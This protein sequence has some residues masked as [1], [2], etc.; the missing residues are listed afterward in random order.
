M[1]PVDTSPPST[2]ASFRGPASARRR[3]PE[4]LEV[5][6]ILG[7]VLLLNYLP[8]GIL[9]IASLRWGILVSQVFFIALPVFLGIRWF[10]LD[11]R[12]VLPLVRP[13]GRALLGAALG[14]VGL[15]HVLNY[16]M[17]WQD[18]FFPLPDSLRTLFDALES[19]DGPLDFVLLLLLLGVVPGV[20]EEILFRGFVH[21]GLRQS[22]ESGT[23]ATVVG[24]LVFAGFHLIPWRFDVL[25]IIGLYLGYLVQR[26]GS[27]VPSMVAHALINMLSVG[28]AAL[29]EETQR[30]F[31]QSPWSHALACACLAGA[32]LMLRR[33]PA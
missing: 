14:A 23:T 16:A 5:A 15:N 20:C 26:T 21:S 29:G 17:L 28:L 3:A 10:Y 1:E 32:A 9:Q 24:A 22:F 6:L 4:R 8:G 12:A 18:R 19:F 2:G 25:V 27:L 33:A 11:R 30:A 31:I 7:L 13:T